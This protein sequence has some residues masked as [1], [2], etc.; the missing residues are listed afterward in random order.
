ML[1]HG[2]R[3]AV[4]TTDP[5]NFASRRTCEHLGCVL[6]SVVDVPPAYRVLCSGS[7]RKCRYIWLNAK[8]AAE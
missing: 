5:D 7:Q 4:I 6:E 8:E 3:S 2:L 1:E